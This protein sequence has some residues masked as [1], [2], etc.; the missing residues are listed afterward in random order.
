MKKLI[1]I[2]ILQMFVG[3]M[4]AQHARNLDTMLL[5]AR[6]LSNSDT[7]KVSVLDQ[8]AWDV[9]YTNLDSGLLVA[10]QAIELARELGFSKGESEAQNVRGTIYADMGRYEEAVDAH[11]HAIRLREGKEG[12]SKLGESYH[13]LALV[14]ISMDSTAKS[15]EFQRKA[16][17]YYSQSRDSSGK[18]PICYYLGEA[19]LDKD[20]V[21]QA[22][23]LFKEGAEVAKLYHY[24][25]WEAANLGGLAYCTAI[26]GD[27]AK[28]NMLMQE[29]FDIAKSGKSDYDMMA[30]W[31]RVAKL[32]KFE[33]RYKDAIAAVDSALVLSTTLGVKASRMEHLRLLAELQELNGNPQ[34]AL[35][36]Y[37]K[38]G[39]LKDSILSSKNQQ[40]I[41]NLESVYDKE[42]QEQALEI[43][44]QDG[45]LQKILVGCGIVFSVGFIIVAFLLFGR[46]R[47][48]KIAGLKLHEQKTIIESKNKDITD[49]I[50]YARRIQDAVTPIPEQL[51]NM[52]PVSFVVNKPRAIVSGDFWWIL[53]T[54]GDYFIALGDCSGHGVPGG[55]MSVMAASF[56]NGIV[57][58]NKEHSPDKILFELNKKVRA[59]LQHPDTNQDVPLVSDT[60][61]IAICRIN[62]SKTMLTCSSAAMPIHIARRKQIIEFP[63]SDSSA[64]SFDNLQASPYQAV[65]IP[66]EPGDV[67]YLLSDGVFSNSSSTSKENAVEELLLS[68]DLT[69][70]NPEHPIEKHITNI[71]GNQGLADDI[72]VLGIQIG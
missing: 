2:L 72:M 63:G 67:L 7:T 66:I 18:G 46:V 10:K 40:N 52:F 32:R 1:S 53:E 36:F 27:T 6:T 43:L 47:M 31:L 21:E 62:K 20:S 15:L 29:A 4:M 65:E 13:N 54:Q 38:Y 50:N 51:V 44:R 26:K 14:Y 55:F 64:G 8:I 3:N 22:T 69:K 12:P 59:A 17:Y 71:T 56:L 68:I 30:A 34:V 58:E 60:I 19:L 37:H 41:R 33:K 42:K 25:L 70:K 49:S 16:Y 61:D 28:G 9:S 11:L 24:V 5:R 48:G 23:L 39:M 45:R 57:I 35:D